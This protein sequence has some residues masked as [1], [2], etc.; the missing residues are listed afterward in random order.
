MCT[1]LIVPYM[2]W[3]VLHACYS[4][5][6]YML[7]RCSQRVVLQSVQKNPIKTTPYSCHAAIGGVSRETQNIYHQILTRH[8]QANALRILPGMSFSRN[9]TIQRQESHTAIF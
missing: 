3:I 7:C 6:N 4:Y 1:V 2:L 9:Q 5:V 8:A